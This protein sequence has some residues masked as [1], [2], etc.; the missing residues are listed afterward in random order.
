[1]RTHGETSA[2]QWSPPVMGGMTLTRVRLPPRPRQA[3]MEPARNGRDD[4]LAAA[5]LVFGAGQAAMEPARNGRDD[6]HVDLHPAQDG[7]AAMEPAR[8]GRDDSAD[9]DIRLM[10]VEP[11]WS[12][13]VMGGMTA[14][15]IEP[16]SQVQ[17]PQWSPP[18]MGGMTPL[19]RRVLGAGRPAAME[20]ARNGRGGPT[21]GRYR[22]IGDGAPQWSPP[23]MGGM[24]LG[25]RRRRERD[26]RRAAM[27]PA[28]NGR[29][30]DRDRLPG[31]VDREAAMEPARNGRDD[32]MIV[33]G[34][35]GAPRVPQ[36]SP[37]V[38]GGMTWLSVTLLASVSWPQWSPPVMGGMTGCTPRGRTRCSCRNGARP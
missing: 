19:R 23:V 28:R 2:P 34:E 14:R 5:L 26:P 22:Q 13:P 6:G 29:D 3:A 7:L 33:A 16:P 35:T 15:V 37:P 17:E 20:P 8:N 38:M 21:Q 32:P 4:L 1:M 18:V 9:S 12:P 36:W 10:K 11:Q 24:T 30:D 31:H 27:E 25:R